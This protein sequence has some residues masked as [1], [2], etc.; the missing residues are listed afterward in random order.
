LIYWLQLPLSELIVYAN[1][2]FILIYLLCMLAG[3][4]L[5]HGRSRVM[6]S[7]GSVLCVALL[8]TLGWKSL[9]ALGMLTVLWLVLPIRRA[10]I[11]TE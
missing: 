3:W 5:L 8:L 10:V 7:I 2:I 4:R 1:G 11:A 6:A 9:Y